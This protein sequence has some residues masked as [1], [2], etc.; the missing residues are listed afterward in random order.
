MSAHSQADDQLNIR[1]AVPFFRVNDIIKSIRFYEQGLGFK[2]TNQWMDKGVL[3]WC[4]LERDGV[5]VMLQE[6]GDLW[7]GKPSP[8]KGKGLGVSI[9]FICRDAVHLYQEFK[10]RNVDSTL[11]FVG[12]GMWV[13]SVKDPDGYDLQFESYTNVPE[14]TEWSGDEGR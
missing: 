13:T 2:L 8:Q 12:N 3:R 6:F 4:L 1:Q 5:N 11:P 14:G 9:C 10:A 7:H